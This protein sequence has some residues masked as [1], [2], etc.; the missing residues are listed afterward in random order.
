MQWMSRHRRALAVAI[1][2]LVALAFAPAAVAAKGASKR[3]LTVMSR[4]LYLGADIIKLA[5]APDLPTEQANAKALHDTVLATNFPARAKEIADEIKRTKPD[6]I[7][8]QEVARYFRGADGVH[9]GVNNATTPL[10]DW[11]QILQGELRARGLNYRVVSRQD[12]LDVEVPSDD[13]YDIRLVLGNAVL[14]KAGRKARVKVISDRNG[15]FTNQLT[16][17]L[18]DQQVVLKRGYAGFVGSVGGRRFLFLDP[19][20]EAYS[21]DIAGAQ[22][23]EMLDTV[24]SNRKL[25]TI[26]AGDFNSDPAQAGADAKAYNAAIGA[27]FVNTGKRVSTCC[28]DERLDNAQSKLTQWIDHVLVR[29]KMRVLRWQV[30]GNKVGDKVD[31]LW[32]SDHA[33]LVVKL[34]LR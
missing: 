22:L 15:I 9:D 13:G 16:V 3:N 34:R 26:L 29:P 10:F 33:G 20:A 14:V 19:H 7:G 18:P 27:G 28:Q 32:P 6:V 1:A 30:I 24:A 17:P 23:Q 5:S 25:P 8:L 11:L 12:E 4:N 31:G 21:G 2:A